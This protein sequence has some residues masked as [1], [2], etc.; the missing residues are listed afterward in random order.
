MTSPVFIVNRSGAGHG[1]FEVLAPKHL[2]SE[3]AVRTQLHLPGA[4]ALWIATGREGL[5]WMARGLTGTPRRRRGTLLVMDAVRDD[6]LALFMNWF[7]RVVL[8]PRSRLPAVEL[9]AVFNREDRA[10][11][12]VGGTIDLDLGVA[13]L[14]RGDLSVLAA[15]LTDFPTSGDGTHPDFRDF[16][17]E[18]HGR[19]LRFGSYEAAFDAILYLHDAEYRRRIREKR[20]GETTLGTAVRRLRK[21]RC[22]RLEDLGHL[23]KTVARIERG[24]VRRP[25]RATLSA[26][27]ERLGTTVEE[28]AQ[29]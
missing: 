29:F 10:D 24:E 6:V 5:R 13:I 19:T 2:S 18:D 25:R 16:E 23:A 20:A 4:G 26:V 9:A 21:Q 22:L 8:L 15:P 14:L 28:L 3:K 17:V 7:D 27:A 1:P 11:F 12:C